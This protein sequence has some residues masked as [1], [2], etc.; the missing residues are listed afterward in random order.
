MSEPFLGEVKAFAFDFAPRG[1][2]A[3]DGQILPIAQNQALFALLGVSYGG[4]GRSN[5]ALPDLRGRTPLHFDAAHPIGL[6][7][8][9]EGHPLTMDEMPA[10]RHSVVASLGTD[11]VND[12]PRDRFLARAAVNA[13]GPASNP[14]A[15]AANTVATVG[16]AT[17]HE[18][19]QPFLTLAFAIALQGIFPPR[20]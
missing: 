8:G 19:R 7:D 16:S 14:S 11:G 15:M 2:A 6:R 9:S 3:S 1:W 5:F 13:Y 4:D 18:N 10:H 12:D 17:P 20:D